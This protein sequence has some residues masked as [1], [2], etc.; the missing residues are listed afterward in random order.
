MYGH[1]MP[2]LMERGLWRHADFLKLWAA[3]AVSSFGSRITREGLPLAAILTL[4]A[5]P[6]QLGILAALARGPGLIVGL[7]AGGWIDSAHRRPLLIGADLFRMA[8][9]MT[10][11]LAAWSHLLTM[12]Q[13]YVV[14]A[15][16]GAA[17][18]LFDIADHAY[19]PSLIGKPDLLEGNAKLAV[20]ESTAEIGGPAL[21]GVLFQVFTPPIAILVDAAT[22]LVSALSLGA[23]RTPEPPP[24]PRK[25]NQHWLADLKFG[26]E[27]VMGQPLIRPML[28]MTVVQ[29]F[30]GSFFAG[31]YMLFA[32]KTLGLST[33]LMGVTIAVGGVGALSGALLARLSVARLGPGPAILVMG[34]ISAVSALLIPLAPASV[35]GGTVVLMIGQWFGDAFAVAAMVPAGTLRQ[36]VFPREVLGRTG[37]VFHVAAGAMAVVGAIVGGVAAEHVGIRP[38]MWVGALGIIAGQLIL[39]FSP[40]RQLSKMPE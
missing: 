35:V 7:F 22:Y 1:S 37:A 12:P 29:T 30:F 39:V 3:Q 24:V 40:L 23:I 13:L 11:P 6:A 18:I 20:T 31:L 10:V 32:I 19:L 16:I 21:A 14:A 27:A 5:S 26:F 36:T 9:L 25:R 8:L 28:I 38:T 17:S 4:D 33:S 34:M 15:L 2:N